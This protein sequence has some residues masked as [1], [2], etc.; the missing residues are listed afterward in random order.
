MIDHNWGEVLEKTERQLS[1]RQHLYNYGRFRSVDQKLEFA[2]RMNECFEMIE[3]LVL[4]GQNF[5]AEHSQQDDG[6][7][8]DGRELTSVEDDSPDSEKKVT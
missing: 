6:D 3:D 8:D 2:K 4:R 5:Q 7:N 1:R